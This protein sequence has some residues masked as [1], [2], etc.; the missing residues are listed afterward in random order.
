[1][2]ATIVI[3]VML[4]LVGTISAITIYSG[5]CNNITFPN[6]DIVN[7]SVEGN[8]SDMDGFNWNKTGTLITYCFDI[9][10]KPDSFNLTWYNYQSVS[11]SSS[12]SSSS[13][14]SLGSSGKC[15]TNWV[16]S[17][18]TI[19]DGE[20]KYRTC[21]K[22]HYSCEPR[23][24]M[25][26]IKEYCGTKEDLDIQDNKPI[27]IDLNNGS[28]ELDNKLLI[29]FLI[30]LFLFIIFS[31]GVWIYL[32]FS[33]KNDNYEEDEEKDNDNKELLPF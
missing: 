24:E 14:S 22:M 27:I 15:Q 32:F 6:T 21:E 19:C 18:W 20:Y 16:C 7:L 8:S 23:I 5:E 26:I 28:K 10:Y 2:K 29:I 9:N 1:M 33:N 17:N 3:I 30:I 13:S 31:I 11:I 4:F 12:G 25:P